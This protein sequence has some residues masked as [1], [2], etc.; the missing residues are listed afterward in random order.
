MQASQ[1]TLVN[2]VPSALTPD[3][4][5]GVVYA[6]AKVGTTV[7]VG[8]SFTSVAPHGSSAT[9]ARSGIF[10]FD[11]STGAI[12]TSFAPVLDGEVDTL[13]AGPDGTV[14]AGGTF[15]T[16]GGRANRVVRLDV[17]TGAVTAGWTSPVMDGSVTT[18]AY[19]AGRLFVGGTFTKA[20]Y[21]SIDT[22]PAHAGLVSLD[23]VAGAVTSYVTSQVAGHHAWTSTNGYAKGPVGVKALDVDPAGAAMVI[24]GNFTSVDG[25]ARDQ[26]ARLVLGATSAVLDTSWATASFTARCSKLFDSS[27]RDVQYSPDGSYF[28]VVSSGGGGT[29]PLNTDGSRG[30]CDSAVRFDSVRSGSN[31]A[32]TW[33]DYTGNDSF[34]SVA[35][36]G[37]AV[38][39]GG[40]ARWV[41]NCSGSDTPGQGA[42][43]R[44]GIVALAPVNGLPFS[45]NPGR[46]PRGAGAYALMAT[47]QGLYV[48]SDTDYIGNRKYLRRKIA[49][50]PLA[51]GAAAPDTTTA[52]LPGT[53]YRAGGFGNTAPNVLHRV[54]V[55]GPALTADDG[56][57]GWAA[58][59]SD[60]SAY[61]SAGSTVDGASYSKVDATVP[62]DTPNALFAT[63]R[64]DPG[65]KG[66]GSEMHWAF[67]VPVGTT[68]Q[69]RLYFDE[70]NSTLAA[71][72]S[73]TFDVSVDGHAWLS[74]MDVAGSAGLRTGTMRS[75]TVTS[76]GEVDLD[77]THEVNNPMVS[78]IEIVRTAAPTIAAGGSPVYRVNSGGPQV[79]ST[80]TGPA[81]LADSTTTVTQGTP[82]RRGGT[83]SAYTT[84]VSGYD[85]T[86]PLKTPT[87]LFSDEVAGTSTGTSIHYG[88]P[89]P[90]GT[91]ATVRLYF[92]NQNTSTATA[93]SRTFNIAVDGTTRLSSFDVVA[94]AGA[95]RKGTMKSFPV[96]SDGMVDVDL[97]SASGYPFVDAV[98]IVQNAAS[99]TTTPDASADLLTSRHDDGSAIGASSTA[100]WGADWHRAR[101]AFVLGSTLFYGWS[102]GFLHQRIITGTT[103]GPDQVVDPYND[104]VWS[105][106]V[107]GS[108]ST[109]QYYRGVLPTFYTA[110][111]ENVT[112]MFYSGGRIYYTLAGRTAMYSRY[113]TPDSGVVG[114]EELTVS[115][116]RDWS[117]V[118]GAFLSGSTLYYAT[119]SDGVLRSVAWSGTSATGSST[120]VDSSSSWAGRAL[121]LLADPSAPAAVGYRASTS[122]NAQ[123]Q[124]PAVQVP[125]PVRAGDTLLLYATVGSTAVTVSTP[126]GWTAVDAQSNG[127]GGLATVLFSKTAGPGDSGSSVSVPLSARAKVTLTLAA[128]SG[129]DGAVSAVGYA[130]DANTA[131]H[132]TPGTTVA[133][134]GSWVVSYWADKSATATTTWTAAA[135]VASRTSTFGSASDVPAVSSLLADAAAPVSAGAQGGVTA[136]ADSVASRGNSWSVVLSPAR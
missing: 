122:V 90:A 12:S 54:N 26:A 134:D 86:V 76:D 108:T 28:V 55:G 18:M 36:T 2:T 59:T 65:V 80:D 10:A 131:T 52:S 136:T 68:V 66:D 82:F 133:T 32:P 56:G 11:Q 92:A 53:V 125:T 72:G 60:P 31:V 38:Y 22:V 88:F 30:K 43:P 33:T 105:T 46:N 57:I 7:V 51:G 126:T 13:E 35:V 110:E 117:G 19:A 116:G 111:M 101:G 128:Y 61:R 87:A 123:L 121:F 20:G 113:F 73:R 47:D 34:W 63:Q 109:T 69:V 114:S 64:H 15:T 42:V 106:V 98:E 4:Q 94:T 62:V 89:M 29:L 8:G 135:G 129:A 27:V 49:F 41:N 17:A 119:R 107:T 79:A 130:G 104:P 5:D 71:A 44:P 48:G 81:W 103:F 25:V 95:T 58:D 6:L 39:A 100:T 112:A 1:S 50:F 21:G 127:T 67:P 78:G 97:T 91:A 14:Y 124:V 93:G 70:S 16:V 9:V 85:T 37:T 45:W 75:T 3:I 132:T 40:H 77:F 102:D 84:A 118:A 96:T 24:I 99:P 120:V 115:D 74:A 23:P 83:V